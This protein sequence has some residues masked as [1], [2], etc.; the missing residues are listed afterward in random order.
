VRAFRIRIDSE[1]KPVVCEPKDWEMIG[2]ESMRHK[3]SGQ[4]FRIEVDEE[5][6]LFDLDVQYWLTARPVR[7]SELGEYPSMAKQVELGR[8]AIAIVLSLLSERLESP[9]L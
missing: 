3:P 6:V 8:A 7:M 2:D 5:A 1:D 9:G 4:V